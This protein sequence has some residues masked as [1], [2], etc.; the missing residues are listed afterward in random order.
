MGQLFK[1]LACG[2]IIPVSVILAHKLIFTG[3]CHKPPPHPHPIL[4]SFLF[5]P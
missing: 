2:E 4:S 1:G 3:L 5:R